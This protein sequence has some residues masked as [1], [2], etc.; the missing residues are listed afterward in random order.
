VCGINA[1]ID[2]DGRV[3]DKRERVAA[4]NALMVYRG[5][6]GE[7]VHADARVAVGMRR[8]SIIDVAG[9][10]QP[11]FNEDRTLVIVCNGEIYNFVEL[12]EDLQR[13][14]HVFSS[15]SD[16]ET[17]LHLYEEKGEACLQDLRGMFAFVIWDMAKGRVFAARDRL[18]IKPLYVSRQGGALWLSSELRPI[19]AAAGIVPTLRPASVHEFLTYS[20]PIDQRH[21]L[22]EEVDRLLPGEYLLADAK[23]STCHRYWEPR[24]GGDQGL[25]DRTDE[26]LLEILQTAIKIHLRS[27]VPVGIL[28]SGGL[29]SSTLATMASRVG[30]NHTALCAG[31]RGNH[32]VD[33]RQEARATARRLGMECL[34]I[35][36][37]A[38]QFEAHFKELVRYCDEPVGDI[39][40]M[41]QWGIYRQARALG[42]KVLLSG[43]GGDEVMFGYPAWNGLGTALRTL[44]G[45]P[46][47]RARVIAGAFSVYLGDQ[48]SGVARGDLAAAAGGTPQPFL[49][50]SRHAPKGPDE[51]TAVLLGSY[52]VHNG[53]QLAD[54]LGMGCSVE[55]RVPL[56]DHA[57]LESV[58]QLPLARRHEPGRSKPLL[59]RL[60]RGRLPESLLEADKRGFAPPEGFVH[61]ITSRKTDELLGGELVRLGWVDPGALRAIIHRGEA[62]PWLH[63]PRLRRALGLARSSW[64]LFRLLAFERWF[65][66]L[67][68]TAR[69]IDPPPASRR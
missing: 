21:T 55:V 8:L 4:M 41:A 54:K 20:Y 61:E 32:D 6:D 51:I 11:I 30:M 52:L 23:G 57:F 1:I 16:V 27:D 53:C 26:E 25:V 3:A 38:S 44:D 29:D 22:V 15:H 18:G 24:F 40:A 47:A 10:G 36:L 12:M 50:L 46:E 48:T 17:I 33:E 37:D 65:Q 66:N 2:F 68:G 7:G 63:S 42:F 9:G 58:L 43:L 49:E 34:E 14:G 13:R 59:R 69:L 19:V 31:Y 64:F 39:A 60:M 35:E 5:P 45:A 56:L 62:L 28:L 67:V